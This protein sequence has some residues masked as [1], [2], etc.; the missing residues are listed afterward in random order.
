MKRY[1]KEDIIGVFQIIDYLP[2]MYLCTCL[3]CRNNVAIE[4]KL[5]P[6]TSTV[7]PNCG[8]A[9]SIQLKS[10]G[11]S[12]TPIYVYW[13]NFIARYRTRPSLYD[14]RW[15]TFINFYDDMGVEFERLEQRN[16]GK[17]LTIVILRKKELISKSNCV[18]VVKE[19]LRR[20]EIVLEEASIETIFDEMLK[21]VSKKVSNNM[22]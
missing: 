15:N 4:G 16:F 8:N 18:W 5:L 7:C 9:P 14:S 1:K 21:P 2:S 13:Q 20:R 12:R 19:P 11:K 3:K 6:R 10:R 17:R 22:Q